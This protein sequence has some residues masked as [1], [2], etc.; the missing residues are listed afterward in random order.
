[1]NTALMRSTQVSI[2]F[3]IRVITDKEAELLT[4][5]L[6]LLTP[7]LYLWQMQQTANR[8]RD[9]IKSLVGDIKDLSSFIFKIV[10]ITL[11]SFAFGLG[12]MP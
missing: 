7:I 9:E 6:L 8:V 11:K 4:L 3:S 12:V 5:L 2:A 1:M 10:V